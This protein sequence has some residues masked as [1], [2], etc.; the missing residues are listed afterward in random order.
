MI[1]L[2]EVGYAYPQGERE[3][4]SDVSLSVR[5]GECIFI[6]GPSGA[7]KTTLCMAA[8]GILEHEYGG[9][10]RGRVTIQ[11]K[12]VKEYP[13]LSEISGLVGMVFDDPEA[14]LIFTTVEEE[15]LSALER[16]GLS[17]EQI[18][19]RLVSIMEITQLLALKDRAPYALSG[20]Q[21]QRVVLATTLALGTDILILDEPTAELDERGTKSIVSVLKNLK[22]EGKTII[23]TEHKF[24]HFRDLVD[25]LVVMDMGKVRSL[26]TPEDL[27][28]DEFVKGV[29]LPDFS[30]IQDFSLPAH[31]PDPAPVVSVKDLVHCYGDVPALRG[32]SLDI[33][34]GEFIAIVGENGSGKTT[35]IK[36]FN[37][38]LRSTS[39]T[40]TVDGKNAGTAPV[41][42]LAHTVGLVF[43]NPDHM[44]FANT[45]AEEI[46]FGTLNLGIPHP[47][48]VMERM[49]AETGLLH[50]RDLYPRWLSRGERQRL[51]IACVL[52]M[53]PKVIVLDEPTTGL[54]GREAR[55]VMEI[56]K[57]LQRDGRAIVMVTH[58]RQMAEECTDRIITMESGK[59][60]SD[61][62]RRG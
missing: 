21:K 28:G 62:R 2:E 44:F 34:P 51:A 53:Q 22:A 59:I 46:K 61:I 48:Q 4:I 9:Q 45:V 16:R 54:D 60:S 38:L 24:S 7:G 19:A 8:A 17:P 20:G 3:A 31:P 32:V 15:I 41:S 56:L 30:G 57:H 11:G 14:Q 55:E 33:T 42:E 23:L 6:T 36:H 12:D 5:P 49:L 37:G 25:R 26:G 27:V 18:E 50:A 47:D 39:G 35:L 40:V 1:E 13:G 10:K 52:A 43:Q 29:I 58:S